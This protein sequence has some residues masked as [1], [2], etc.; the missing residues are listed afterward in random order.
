MLTSNGQPDVPIAALKQ[1]YPQR[2]LQHLNLAAEGRL[3][4]EQA[5]CRPTEV[6]LLGDHYKTT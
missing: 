5:F 4:H 3:G 1:R 2:A 6:Q